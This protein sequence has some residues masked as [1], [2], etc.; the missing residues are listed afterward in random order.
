MENIGRD[1]GVCPFMLLAVLFLG[2]WEGGSVITVICR[3]A[4]GLAYVM[5][6]A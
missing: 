6:Q 4:R 1:P 3:H 2:V 5:I